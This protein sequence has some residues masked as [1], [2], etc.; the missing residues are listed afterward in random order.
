[1]SEPRKEIGMTGIITTG[2]MIALGLYDLVVVSTHGAQ[3]SVSRFVTDK[4][5]D[6]PVFVLLI[7]WLLCHFLGGTMPRRS[8][9]ESPK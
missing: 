6:S 3:A 2:L 5:G 9:E 8:R 1:M 7:G 4:A